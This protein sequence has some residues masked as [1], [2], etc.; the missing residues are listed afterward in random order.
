[1]FSFYIMYTYLYFANNHYFSFPDEGVRAHAVKW[2]SLASDDTL[3]MLMPQLCLALR[4]ERF[5]VSPLARLLL[6]R[7]LESPRFAHRLYWQLVHD[8]PGNSPQVFLIGTI[9]F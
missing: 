8:I 7:S 3:I 4:Y 9:S 5:V 2:L 6:S 1:M